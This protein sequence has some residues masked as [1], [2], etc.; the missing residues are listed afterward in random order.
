MTK[1]W[2]LAGDAFCR[3][4]DCMLKSNSNGIAVSSYLYN[5]AFCYRKVIKNK[6]LNC[7]RR[8]SQIL[9]N[10]GKFS[11]AA[12]NIKEMAEI[13]EENMN[14]DETM[15]LYLEAAEIFES[16]NE[17]PQMI[18]CLQKVAQLKSSRNVAK[19]ED[20]VQIYERLAFNSIDNNCLNGKSRNIY[21][22]LDYARLAMNDAIGT[23][24]A[25]NNYGDRDASFTTSREGI[26]TTITRCYE[27]L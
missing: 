27:Q 13:E 3:A 5:A 15:A 18:N 23:E 1:E 4:A 19:Y 20:A 8:S 25:L 12:R 14:V 26:F 16:E 2:E 7:L 24:R 21:F 22:K 10:L 9:M 17:N 6:V 11:Q